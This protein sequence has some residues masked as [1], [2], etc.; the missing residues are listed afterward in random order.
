MD[1]TLEA[2]QEGDPDAP[3]EMEDL[4]GE[5]E[6]CLSYWNDVLCTGAARAMAARLDPEDVFEALIV[7]E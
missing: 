7:V 4:L 1:K 3:P 5:L 2:M 6:T